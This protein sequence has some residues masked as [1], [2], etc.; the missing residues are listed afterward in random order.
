MAQHF[1]FL[2]EALSGKFSD[3]DLIE[4]VLETLQNNGYLTCR[5]IIDDIE[6]RADSFILH[7]IC[8]TV[9]HLPTVRTVHQILCQ[10]FR[11]N[12]LDH[13][14][15][16]NPST[17]SP[18]PQSLSQCFHW[19]ITS[20]IHF[21][22]N[23]LAVPLSPETLQQIDMM[24][25][26]RVIDGTLM[27]QISAVE[28]IEMAQCDGIQVTAPRLREIWHR[29]KDFNVLQHLRSALHQMLQEIEQQNEIQSEEIG[30]EQSTND[31]SWNGIVAASDFTAGS[32]VQHET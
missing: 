18:V 32:V 9:V 14:S 16:N 3:N 8:K 4:C 27:D 20:I 23:D 7:S 24:V 31:I 22:T 10:I 28:F 5:D 30:N 2:R 1:T 29:I 6:D 13:N 17:E 26:N 21:I 12:I 11:D 19:H 25:A 15:L